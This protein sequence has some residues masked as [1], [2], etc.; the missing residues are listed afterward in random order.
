MQVIDFKYDILYICACM[1][2]SRVYPIQ[3]RNKVLNYVPVVG[4]NPINRECQIILT[5]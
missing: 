2:L 1:L 3:P 4:S 5:T